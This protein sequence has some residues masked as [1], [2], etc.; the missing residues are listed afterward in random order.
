MIND[1]VVCWTIKRKLHCQRSMQ[2]FVG[3]YAS[4][5]IVMVL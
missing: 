4:I 3:H 2:I 5:E 1:I